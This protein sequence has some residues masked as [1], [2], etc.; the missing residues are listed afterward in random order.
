M[1]SQFER[2]MESVV[3]NGGTD[4]D[5]LMLL[6][7]ALTPLIAA[8]VRDAISSEIALLEA[9]L[10]QQAQLVV[11]ADPEH[12]ELLRANMRLARGLCER[13]RAGRIEIDH[14]GHVQ[15]R[16]ARSDRGRNGSPR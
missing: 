12:M 5:T 15:L 11:R 3:T 6:T 2:A 16:N 10:L 13:I 1:P 7:R 14:A 8:A 4:A 9:N